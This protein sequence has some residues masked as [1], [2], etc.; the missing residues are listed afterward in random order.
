M[1]KITCV[2]K[3]NFI[4]TEVVVFK[5]LFILFLNFQELNS[6]STESIELNF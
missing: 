3:K 1:T 2:F 4:A 5:Y 6:L